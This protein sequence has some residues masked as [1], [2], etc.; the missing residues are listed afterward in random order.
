MITK[1]MALDALA[2]VVNRSGAGF[3]YPYQESGAPCVY[4]AN[5]EPSCGVAQALD[6]LGV[7][8]E[9]LASMDSRNSDQ[10]G[11]VSARAIKTMV[12]EIEITRAA[13]WVLDSFQQKQ[14]AGATWGLALTEARYRHTEFQED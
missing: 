5:G 13:C 7:D 11:P 6:L 8:R 1:D 3:V 2:T 12:P 10:N 14:D 9:V 4:V